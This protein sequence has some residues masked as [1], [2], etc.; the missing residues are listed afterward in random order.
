MSIPRVNDIMLE[1]KVDP[2]LYSTMSKFA[3]E[4]AIEKN[5]PLLKKE[6][7]N[8]RSKLIKITRIA[9]IYYKHLSI[10]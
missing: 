4:K 10:E 1:H 9:F 8:G 6:V 5:V 2:L 7:Q 3:I